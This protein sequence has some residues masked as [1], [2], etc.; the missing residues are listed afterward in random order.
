MIDRTAWPK[1]V[2]GNVSLPLPSAKA[3]TVN[4]DYRNFYRCGRKSQQVSNLQ[5][6]IAL[7]EE[8]QSEIC[9]SGNC[10]CSFCQKVKDYEQQIERV[11][12]Y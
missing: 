3:L 9:L 6:L 4:F 7:A 8:S 10:K 2:Q 12:L 1:E 5:K 11:R